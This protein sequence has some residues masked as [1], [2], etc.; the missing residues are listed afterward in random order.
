MKRVCT[1]FLLALNIVAIGVSG[2][3]SAG[4]EPCPILKK[5]IDWTRSWRKIIFDFTQESAVPSVAMTQQAR[6]RV[7]IDKP[8]IKWE[9][10][11]PEYY[12]ILASDKRVWMVMPEDRVIYTEALTGM[13]LE[14]VPVLFLTDPA[15][16]LESFHCTTGETSGGT[17][18]VNLTSTSG[19][20]A[21]RSAALSIAADGSINNVEL[22]MQD[23]STNSFSFSGMRGDPGAA[24]HLFS[25][26]INGE[27]YSVLSFSGEPL[28]D[29]ELPSRQAGVELGV[30]E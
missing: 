9:Y 24:E 30:K 2:P 28:T 7:W 20:A 15:P 11:E 16:V 10:L 12:Y 26:E 6:G 17:T 8:W 22:T 29:Y 3:V 5:T 1:A 4:D 27:T 25:I 23:E 14:R 19:T 18:T 21:V 13:E